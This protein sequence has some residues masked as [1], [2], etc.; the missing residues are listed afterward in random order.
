MCTQGR[1]RADQ[2]RE[3]SA[4]PYRSVG[5]FRLQFSQLVIFR[6]KASLGRTA[7]PAPL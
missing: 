4:G 2:V 6:T 5:S 3:Y 7:A 1:L